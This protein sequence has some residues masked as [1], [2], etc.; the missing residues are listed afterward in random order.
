MHKTLFGQD[1]VSA[2]QV[3]MNL[4]RVEVEHELRTALLRLRQHLLLSP[5]N[6]DELRRVLAKSIASVTTPC[7]VMRSLRWENN[8]LTTE[9]R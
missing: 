6:E 2:I 8:P 4:H 1:I 5:E 9:R 7:Y 3:P